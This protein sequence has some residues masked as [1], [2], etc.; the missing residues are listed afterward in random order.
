[1][2]SNCA[3]SSHHCRQE[4]VENMTILDVGCGFNEK[5]HTKRA[6]IGIDLKRGL[7]D[8]VATTYYLPFKENSFTKVIMSHIL[9]HLSK[10]LQALKEINRVLSE[11]GFLEMEVPNPHAFYVFK[12]IFLRKKDSMNGNHEHVFLFSEVELQ[13]LLLQAGF[14]LNKIGYVNSFWTQKRL[15]ISFLKK[16]IYHALWTLYPAFQTSILATFRKS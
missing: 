5:Q 15:N 10:P 3:H 13:N 8:V 2:I 1:M 16:Y 6:D 14:V 11:E 12:D 9:E 4:R 7:C